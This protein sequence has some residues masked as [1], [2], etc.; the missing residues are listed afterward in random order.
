[1]RGI[2]HD[3]AAST[4]AFHMSQS[5]TQATAMV[6]VGHETEAFEKL[7]CGESD[8]DVQYARERSPL[9]DTYP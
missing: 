2:V 6:I 1:M 9:A 8:I 4:G 7:H 5:C 3:S